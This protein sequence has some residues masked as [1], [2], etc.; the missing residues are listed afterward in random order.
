VR[1]Y[2]IDLMKLQLKQQGLAN[3]FKVSNKDMT[4]ADVKKLGKAGK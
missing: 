4:A 1:Q 2:G 3:Q